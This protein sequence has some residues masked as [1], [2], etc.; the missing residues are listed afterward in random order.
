MRLGMHVFPTLRFLSRFSARLRHRH[1]LGARVASLFFLAVASPIMAA[2]HE[3]P[4]R[5]RAVVAA[6]VVGESNQRSSIDAP[7]LS[8]PLQLP[9][10]DSDPVAFDPPGSSR[11]NSRQTVGVRCE[12][13]W[14][15]Y[16]PVRITRNVMMVELA[17]PIG[18]GQTLE[19]ADLRLAEHPMSSMPLGY[20]SQLRQALGQ[21]ARQALPEGTVLRP[22]HLRAGQAVQRGQGV[23]LIVERG[24]MQIESSGE[25]LEDGAIGTWVKVTNPR[26]GRM[27]E[28]VVDAIGVVRIP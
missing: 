17:R 23:R 16:V 1:A 20:M 26:S 19:S 27:V 14:T 9:R 21:V 7:T 6:H 13:G 25:A 5:L 28:G 22:T 15:L 12:G 10:C 18:P 4:E 11:N 24:G 8:R 3:D 2:E